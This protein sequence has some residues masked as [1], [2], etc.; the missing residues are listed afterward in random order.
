MSTSHWFSTWHH[1]MFINYIKTQKDSQKYSE[2]FFFLFHYFLSFKT[3]CKFTAL[4]FKCSYSHCSF[5]LWWDMGRANGKAVCFEFWGTSS[6]RLTKVCIDW[7]WE[8]VLWKITPENRI[9]N[10]FSCIF[11]AFYSTV[12]KSSEQRCDTEPQSIHN[13]ILQWWWRL[14]DEQRIT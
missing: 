2:M 8:G 11:T 6:A 9:L 12:H 7:M 5:E 4:F 14:L 13:L 1:N 3:L 10:Y